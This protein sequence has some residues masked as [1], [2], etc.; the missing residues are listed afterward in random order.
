MKVPFEF[1]WKTKMPP[2][3]QGLSLAYTKKIF[4]KKIWGKTSRVLWL[5]FYCILEST[6]H[7]FFNCPVATFIWRVVH[8]A[9][10]L[11]SYDQNYDSLFGDWLTNFNKDLKSLV[12]L[13]CGVVLW[14]IWKT[15][16]NICFNNKRLIEPTYVI[17]LSYWLDSW[18]ILL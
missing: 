15:R 8:V 6:D 3:N 4:L 17:F 7:P 11:K 2:K 10:N 13:G 1:I 5:L 18:A 14:V 9:F 12:I 16:N